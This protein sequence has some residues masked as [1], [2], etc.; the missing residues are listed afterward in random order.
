MGDSG[1]AVVLLGGEEQNERLIRLYK[2]AY[3]RNH[4]GIVAFI[5]EHNKKKTA[6]SATSKPVVHQT[7]VGLKDILKEKV[8]DE[9]PEDS[10]EDQFEEDE[11][12]D[13]KTSL[14]TSKSSSSSSS[15]MDRKEAA[16][17]KKKALNLLKAMKPWKVELEGDEKVLPLEGGK[18]KTVI[19]DDV[20]PDDEETD[21]EGEEPLKKGGRKSLTVSIE[22][23]VSAS[24]YGK[25]VKIDADGEEQSAYSRDVLVVDVEKIPSQQSWASSWS[26]QTNVAIALMLSA[27]AVLM[28]GLFLRRRSRHPGFIE[29]SCI[30][31]CKSYHLTLN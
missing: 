6:A 13:K 27:M 24:K 7:V 26:S 10:D 19:L 12:S 18:K 31:C 21:E 28:I 23:I 20:D 30:G 2:Q 5:E 3:E 4:P 11:D 25:D 16:L 14:S 8:R 9:L 22:P 29:V 15:S 1:D 17:D